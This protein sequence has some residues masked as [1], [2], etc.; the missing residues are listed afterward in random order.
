MRKGFLAFVL[1]WAVALGLRAQ[2][3]QQMLAALPEGQYDGY[4]IVTLFDSTR[5]V[6]EE[7]GLSHVYGHVLYKVLTP[8]GGRDFNCV[9]M[10]YDP[11]SA[12]AEIQ[13]VKVHRKSGLVEKIDNP[14]LDYPA[15]ARMIYWGACQKMVAIGRLEPGDA[16]EYVTYKKGFTYALL[17]GEDPD[18]K[19]IPPMRGHFYD[20][21]PFW[22]HQPVR[23]KVYSLSVLPS[24]KVQYDV[25][26]GALKTDRK[27]T[28][29]RVIYT[30]TKEDIMPIDKPAHTLADND[31]QTKLLLSTAENWQ[32]KSTWFYGVNEDYG[33]FVP[34]EEVKQK[35]AELLR[36]A[37]SENDSISILTHWVADNMRYSGISMGEGEGFTLHK[38]EM[39]FT[40]RCGVCKDKAGML[41][42]MLRA[43]GFKAYAAMT[44]AGERID[45]IPADQFNHCV[46]VVQ[47]R[48]GNYQLLDPTWVPGV[49]E[50]WSSAE[51][52]QNYLMGLPQGADLGLTPIS[53]AENHYL[54]MTATTKLNKKGALS[55]TVTVTAEGQSDRTVRA[56]FRGRRT[57]WRENVE[58]QLLSLYPNA[59]IKSVKYTDED[60]YLEQ[61]VSITYKFVIPDYATVTDNV[62]VVTPFLA[63]GFYKFA[64]PHLYYDTSLETRTMPFN[65]RCSRLVQLSETMTLPSGYTSA[66]IPKART[67]NNGAVTFDAGYQ[68]ENSVLRFHE[69]IRFGKRVYGSDDWPSYRQAV[70][71]QHFYM[72]TPVVLSR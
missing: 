59:V 2:T 19:Y 7:S 21:V 53:K 54:R 26:H 8:V 55:G 52:Q 17:Q 14:V 31:V 71:N 47:R 20:I 45:Y 64:M 43:A 5:V 30:F 9:K 23:K 27:E 6:M 10:D 28:D 65:D 67:N 72:D 63:K 70:I 16:V 42:A 3:P 51:Q 57:E 40:D 69:N 11:L 50:L 37:K 41:I 36:P 68:L 66:Q 62:V 46:T 61:P 38:C 29:G 49:R 12:Y 58:R 60:R 33:S 13:E 1:L 25:Y 56:V 4:D 18:A 15:P 48:N 22:S 44:M 32:A 39:N 35:V 24:K 34:T